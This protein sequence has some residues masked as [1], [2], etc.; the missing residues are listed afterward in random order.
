MKGDRNKALERD[1]HITVMVMRDLLS[2]PQQYRLSKSSIMKTLFSGV[3]LVSFLAS[4][5]VVLVPLKL[6]ISNHRYVRLVKKQRELVKI[7]SQYICST[8]KLEVLSSRIERLE[9]KVTDYCERTE[10]LISGM[11]KDLER[12]LPKG[13]VG[14]GEGEEDDMRYPPLSSSQIAKIN[15]LESRL[16]LLDRRL[17]SHVWTMDR[18]EQSWRE[19]NDIFSAMPSFWPVPGGHVTSG[20]GMRIHPIS[21]RIQMHEGLDISARPGTPIYATAP[22]I[23]VYA[24]WKGDYGRAVKIDHG[25][26]ITTFYAHCKSLSVRVGQKVEKGQKIA[27]VGTSGLA[28]GPHLHLEVRVKNMPVDPSQYLSVFSPGAEK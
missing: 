1:H 16:A 3:F 10:A 15:M 21:R 28:T 13:A 5:F 23:V 7:E 11:E 2:E 24:G 25:Y 22:G 12:W 14:G 6:S 9:G 19:R 20:F 8:E 4:V 27:T 17:D 26:G 18:L